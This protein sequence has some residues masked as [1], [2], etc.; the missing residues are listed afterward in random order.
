[1]TI[2]HEIIKMPLGCKESTES[3]HYI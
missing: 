1:M 3:L 2:R